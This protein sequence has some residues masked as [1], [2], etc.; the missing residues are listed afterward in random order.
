MGNIAIHK[1]WS[2]YDRIDD[3]SYDDDWFADHYEEIGIKTRKEWFIWKNERMTKKEAKKYKLDYEHS[4]QRQSEIL[5]NKILYHTMGAT[6]LPNDVG[7]G[8]NLAPALNKKGSTDQEGNSDNEEE[9]VNKKCLDERDIINVQYEQTG[10]FNYKEMLECNPDIKRIHLLNL[11]WPH[12]FY[13]AR[14]NDIYRQIE[15][16]YYEDRDDNTIL[17]HLYVYQRLSTYIKEK[18]FNHEGAFIDGS[19]GINIGLMC[20]SYVKTG[21]FDYDTNKLNKI[22]EE[23]TIDFYDLYSIFIFYRCFTHRLHYA[24]LYDGKRRIREKWLQGLIQN[25]ETDKDLKSVNKLFIIKKDERKDKKLTLFD[26][27]IRY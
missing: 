10:K 26:L 23:N 12:D 13:D 18:S 17:K 2:K 5:T 27:V 6:Y 14:H 11:G 3:K 1:F 4:W 24:N 16:Q 19:V 15:E 9:L 25:R 20:A 22:I 21:K 7:L 8:E